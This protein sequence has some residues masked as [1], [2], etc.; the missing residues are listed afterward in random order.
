MAKSRGFELAVDDSD[1]RVLLKA[2]NQVE[3]DLRKNS[4]AQLR[5]A[6]KECANRLKVELYQ[7]VPDSPAPQTRLVAQSIRVK[8]DRTPVVQIGGSKKVGRAY[9]S[10]KSGRSTRASA[11]EL[12]WGVEWGDNAGRF[13]P[14]NSSGNWIRPTVLRFEE[15]TGAI[16][17]YKRAVVRILSDA[18]V[19]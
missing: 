16:D 6:A 4:N 2:L 5:E 17:A 1:V 7:A 12:L 18:G 11:G 8:S 10:R 9:K 19:L 14:R 13:A 3:G 15:S